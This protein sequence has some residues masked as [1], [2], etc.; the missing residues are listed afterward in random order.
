MAQEGFEDYRIRA[1]LLGPYLAHVHI[2]NSA[3]ERPA[4]GG[5]WEPRWA[6]L[7]DGVADF[8][9]VFEAL[10]NVGYDG[11]FVM[12][13]FSGVRPSKEAL[14]HNLEFVRSFVESS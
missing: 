12:E 13:D 1:E 5:V 4:G 14:R 2:K 10:E 8:G 6:P 11:W 3:F 7:E 9:Q